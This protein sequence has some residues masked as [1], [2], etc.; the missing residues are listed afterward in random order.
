L[1][2]E[3]CTPELLAVLALGTQIAV[4]VVQF[5]K[6]RPQALALF[7]FTTAFATTVALIGLGER[8]FSGRLNRHHPAARSDCLGPL[9]I[10]TRDGLACIL[11]TNR[12]GPFA[13]NTYGIS[14]RH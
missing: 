1:A 13:P 3:K 14:D 4:A 9:L 6:V 10:A 12:A 7:V 8:L 11:T 2:G 5:D